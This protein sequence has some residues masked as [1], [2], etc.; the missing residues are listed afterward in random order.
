MPDPDEWPYP[1]DGLSSCLMTYYGT[2]LYARLRVGHEV[3]EGSDVLR[4]L[5]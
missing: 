3:I 1:S 5:R 2:C 4:F